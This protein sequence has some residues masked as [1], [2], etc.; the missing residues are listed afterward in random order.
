MRLIGLAVVLSRGLIL[1][2]LPFWEIL[3]ISWLSAKES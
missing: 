1:A 3:V 2:P